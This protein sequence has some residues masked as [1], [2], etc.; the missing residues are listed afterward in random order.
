MYVGDGKIIH[1]TK[2]KMM[3]VVETVEEFA[4]GRTIT[5]YGRMA[6]DLTEERYVVRVPSVRIDIRI[7]EDLAEEIGRIIG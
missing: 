7:K 2:A 5:G 4:V 3:T 1:A 6:D